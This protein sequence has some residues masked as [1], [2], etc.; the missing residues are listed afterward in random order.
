MCL[1]HS[2]QHISNISAAGITVDSHLGTRVD[3]PPGVLLW[4]VDI[5]AETEG[6]RETTSQRVSERENDAGS[7]RKDCT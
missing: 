4:Y 5:S 7:N 1:N 3:S 6:S 2:H